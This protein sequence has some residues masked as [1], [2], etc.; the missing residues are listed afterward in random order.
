MAPELTTVEKLCSS[1]TEFKF[2]QL[3]L[4]KIRQKIHQGHLVSLHQKHEGHHSFWNSC[5]QCNVNQKW[6]SKAGPRV[7]I[8]VQC[9]YLLDSQGSADGICKAS[10]KPV[11]TFRCFST[12][13]RQRWGQTGLQFY[14]CYLPCLGSVPS[15]L[16]FWVKL[17][18]TRFDSST[19]AIYKANLS[20]VV[21]ALFI[22]FSSTWTH[23]VKIP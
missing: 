19:W 2:N 3:K 17:N 6:V 21:G 23:S 22:Y 11:C 8:I 5:L 14:F 13:L 15:A 18:R 16:V 20:K 10:G 9:G 4:L 7:M 1:Y 12:H